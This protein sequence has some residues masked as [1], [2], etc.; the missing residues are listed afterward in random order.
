MFIE[1]EIN[2]GDEKIDA[3]V[4]KIAQMVKGLDDGF[5]DLESADG[6]HEVEATMKKETGIKTVKVEH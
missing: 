2:E 4:G 6:D 5:S 3:P 1:E